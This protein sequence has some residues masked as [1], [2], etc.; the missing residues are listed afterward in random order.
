MSF[1]NGL[2]SAFGFGTTADDDEEYDSDIPTYAPKPMEHYAS[3][4]SSALIESERIDD[5]ELSE[6]SGQAT[7]V[8]AS[9]S[10]THSSATSDHDD[11]SGTENYDSEPGENSSPSP[12]VTDDTLPADLFDAVIERF[13]SFQPEF[14]AKCLDI[15]A[16]R[17][18]I[19]GGLS[20]ALKSRIAKVAPADTAIRIEKMTARITSLEA[21]SKACESLRQE[22]R[23]LRL[24]VERQKRSL[25]DRINDLEAQVAKHYEEREKFFVARHSSQCSLATP[26]AP[27]PPTQSSSDDPIKADSGQNADNLK[28]AAE[29]Q[30]ELNKAIEDKD[31][32]IARL[33]EIRGQLEAKVSLGDAMLNDLR[34]EMAANR[35]E[36]DTTCAEQQKALEAIH[37][38]IEAFES[39]K[40]R[41]SQRITELK[42]ALKAEKAINVQLAANPKVEEEN[43][44]LLTQN[45][46]LQEEVAR[47]TDRAARLEDD[48]TSLRRTIENNLYNQ[49]NSE[50]KLRSEIND[51]RSQLARALN[52]D[53]SAGSD[54]QPSGAQPSE[55]S[56]LAE[57]KSSDEDDDE[58][59][60]RRP[61]RRRGRPK[62]VN[63]PDDD[64][65][66]N[67]EWFASQK[68]N[69]DFGY[70]EPPRRPTNDDANQLS[71][72]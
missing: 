69:P 48:N 22:N 42:D 46:S 56:Y 53:I 26:S 52:P 68:G 4:S 72:F 44:R 58:K 8:T 54:R 32:E 70:H 45:A 16:E 61:K 18:A 1:W 7:T 15:E 64:D 12:S 66:D 36:Y 49:A 31:K 40:E 6:T 67:T 11:V 20:D 51:L 13:N 24:S 10:T 38:Q 17:K 14:V 60:S 39:I 3:R 2:K 34:N 21:D 65:L 27:T 43:A 5:S 37:E 62:K 9:T 33:N 19:I 71:L 50:M 41:M 30:S 47:I 57:N 28:E 29:R 23:R 25:L 55:A 35:Q 63:I 59:P